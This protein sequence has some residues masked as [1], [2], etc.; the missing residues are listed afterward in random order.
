MKRLLNSP[1]ALGAAWFVVAGVM[2]GLAA[3]AFLQPP[4]PAGGEPV[5][6]ALPE[7]APAP[8]EAQPPAEPPAQPPQ[9]PPVAPPMAPPETPPAEPP[10]Q[11]PPEGLPEG[12]PEGPPETPPEAPAAEPSPPQAAVQPEVPPAPPTPEAEAP[13]NAMPPQTAAPAQEALVRIPVIPP[14]PEQLAY[15]E[16]YRQPFNTEDKRP[17]IAVVLTGLGLSD[18]AT[19]AAIEELPSAVTLSFSPY[20]RDLERWIALARARGHE[21]MLDLP[22]E[23]TTFPNEDPGP[24]ALLTSLAPQD[25]LD[26]LDWV[27][28]RGSAYVGLAG[29]LGSRF[30]ASREAVEPILREVKERG[31]MFLDRRTTEESLVAALAE[32]IGLPYAINNRSVDERQASRVAIDA[33]LAQIERIALTD[34]YAVAMAQ[35]YPVTLDRLA[36]WTA[37]LTARGFAIAPISA[38]ANQQ[39]AP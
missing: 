23:P 36:E 14:A 24:Q 11:V 12:L 26:R 4:P 25:N 2:V 38:L 16:R 30:T 27:L 8:Q 17:R 9:D 6:M 35:P 39:K 10:A 33:R 29:S 37:E 3:F 21:V 31:L 5:S 34:G 20:A 13:A 32:E 1:A 19:A 22:M 28:A 18:S 15:W 7:A